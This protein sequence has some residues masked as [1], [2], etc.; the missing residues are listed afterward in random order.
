MPSDSIIAVFFFAVAISFGAVI[1][2]GPVSAAIVTESPRRGW[3]VGPMVAMGHAVM[4]LLM[5]ILIGMGLSAGMATPAV[6]RIVGGAGGLLLLG[7]GASYWAAV[8]RG[9]MRL[10]RVDAAAHPRSM[11]ALIALGIVTTASN[12]F[13]YAWWV[14]VVPGYLSQA[15]A[16]GLGAMAAFFIG[17]ILSDF[18]W[19]TVLSS[20]TGTG[21]RWLTDARYKVLIVATGGFMIYLGVVFMRS[22]WLLV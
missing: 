17:H 21:R 2:P 18:V 7:I 14:T 5:V 8:W 12:P 1:S 13:W 9:Q 4:E 16:L 15:Q 22:A 19:N 11:G 3:I 20:A 10:P 6:Q